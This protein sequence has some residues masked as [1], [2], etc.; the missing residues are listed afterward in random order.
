MHAYILW[1]RAT[2]GSFRII[3]LVLSLVW[4]LPATRAADDAG[5]AHV[6][7]V[8]WDGV[9]PDVLQE[10]DTP[11]LDKL[12]DTGSYTWNAWTTWRPAT[13]TAIPS[14]H[15][16]APPEVHGVSRWDGPIHAETLSEVFAEAGLASALVGVNGIHGGYSAEYVTGHYFHRQPDA[17]FVDRAIQWFREHRP[18]HMYLYNSRPDGTGHRHGAGSEEYR[19]AIEDAD[20]ELGRFVEALDALGARDR[21]VIVVT[22]DHGMTGR[23]HGYGFATDMRIFSV[24]N[25]PGV[26]VNHEIADTMDIPAMDRGALTARLH[27]V[28]EAEWDAS[29]IT[30]ADAPA[31]GVPVAETFVYRRGWFAWNVTDYVRARWGTGTAAQTRLLEWVMV[32]DVDGEGPVEDDAEAGNPALFSKRNRA[33]F[34]NATEWLEPRLHPHLFLTYRSAGA[35]EPGHIHLRPIADVMVVAGEPEAY[36]GERGSYYV[37]YFN[38]GEAR[39]FYRFDLAGAIPEGATIEEA[40]FRVWCWRMYPAG[41]E[42]TRV[43][44]RAI[45]VAPTISYLMGLRAPRH[46]QGVVVRDLLAD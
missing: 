10:V 5:I 13:L 22:T 32:A 9:R 3:L 14:L 33:A 20:R 40:E 23:S 16:G 8:V 30:W 1:G 44:H 21:T 37:G 31:P 43:A 17:H 11:V 39:V 27:R 46:A 25:G 38:D 35:K 15:T 29:S 7:L 34:F 12:A 2:S 42:A 36:Y 18:A 28:G 45:D 4:G 41:Y 6:V 19:Q 24:W 26:R